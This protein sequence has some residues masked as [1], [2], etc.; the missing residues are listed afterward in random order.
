MPAGGLEVYEH[1][2]A[3]AAAREVAE[4]E[5]HPGGV[6]D[7]EQVQPGAFPCGLAGRSQR[8]LRRLLV[9]RNAGLGGNPIAL[10]LYRP[11]R[12]RGFDCRTRPELL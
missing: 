2:H 1:R 9:I 3:P 12:R 7:G 4:G 11:L 8:S 10:A 5:L 6:R